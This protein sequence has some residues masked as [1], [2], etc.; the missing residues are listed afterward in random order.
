MSEFHASGATLGDFSVAEIKQMMYESMADD[1]EQSGVGYLNQFASW[2]KYED[3]FR[4]KVDALAKAGRNVDGFMTQF[5]ATGDNMFRLAAFISKMGELQRTQSDV[6]THEQM[7]D[8]AGTY[9]KKAFLDYDI[10]SR[11]VKFL[12]QTVFPFVSWPYAFA[13]VLGSIAKNQPWKL[14]S[15]AIAYSMASAAMSAAAGGGD[16]ED[17]KRRARERKD[18]R[19]WFGA[20]KETYLGEWGG[21]HLYFDTARWFSPT[22]LEFKEQPNG[23]MGWHSWP[24]ALTPSNPAVSAL[25][26][27]YGYDPYTG[28]PLDKDTDS[29]F[30]GTVKRMSKMLT[31]MTPSMLASRTGEVLPG[32]RLLLGAKPGLLG[33]EGSE[34]ANYIRTLLAPVS[35]IDE[36][37]SRKGAQLEIARTE[38]AFDTEISG[39]R[40]DSRLGKIPYEEFSETLAKLRERKAERIRE[41]RERL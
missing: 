20:Y 22:P 5:Y 34:S 13:G 29:M 7:V 17:R 39:I 33:H 1:T 30:D 16:D 2:I 10:D 11:A 8:E 32:G 36:A 41:L 28:K 27:G 31:Q 4:R 18:S 15:L 40:R 24:S 25:I 38:R 37:E 12:R 23:F 35:A 21:K 6:K 9:A 26:T 3:R 14:A 19:T